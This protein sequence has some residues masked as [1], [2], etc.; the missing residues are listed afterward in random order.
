MPIEHVD[1]RQCGKV[2]LFALSTCV[3]CKMTKDWLTEQNIAFDYVYVDL[4]E[5]QERDDVVN[6]LQ[7]YNPKLSLPTIVIGG[8]YTVVGLYEDKILEALAKCQA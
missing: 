4:L 1:G 7:K 8:K 2:M 3:F 5:G 6:E